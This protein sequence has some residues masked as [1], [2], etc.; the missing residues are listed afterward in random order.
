MRSLQALAVRLW[1]SRG[2]PPSRPPGWSLAEPVLRV[3]L[4][5]KQKEEAL[6]SA[7]QVLGYCRRAI[8]VGSLRRVSTCGI[9]TPRRPSRVPALRVRHGPGS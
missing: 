9:V 8:L 1:A 5:D 7:I 6:P 3:V 2:G 4:V